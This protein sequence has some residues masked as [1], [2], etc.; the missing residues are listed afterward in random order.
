MEANADLS[1]VVGGKSEMGQPGLGKYLPFLENM[2]PRATTPDAPAKLVPLFGHAALKTQLLAANERGALPASL[3]LQGPRG[4]GKQRLALWLGQ[5]ILCENR[6]RAPCGACT[7]CRFSQ[8][9]VH[10][11]L[12]WYFP[13]PK[14]KEAN[15]SPQEINA[16]L[17]E[18]IAERVAASGVYA[19]P[20]GDEAIFVD[21][22]RAIVQSAVL[23]P[24]M[25]R[26]KAYIIG[27]AERM[28]AQTGADQAANAFLKLLEEPPAD[29]IIILTSSEP[30]ALLP[31][32]KSRVVSIRVGPLLPAEMKAIL[33]DPV[34]A[35]AVSKEHGSAR[36]ADLLAIA[37]GAPGRLL[38]HGAMSAA[39]GAAQAIMEAASSG[40]AAKAFRVAFVQGSSRAR[41]RFSDTLDLLVGLLNERA[42]ANAGRNDRVARGAAAAV[43]AVERAKEFAENNG[44][45]QLIT[46]TLL[47]EITP[48]LS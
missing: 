16:D 41:G 13:R 26:K 42:R 28:V 29:T 22:V 45:P 30:G 17:A 15:P 8:R 47:R 4:V 34:M 36:E 25:A 12:H 33:A 9:L 35:G 11:D 48:L 43:D 19:A 21:T 24:A 39:A 27:D 31:T 3:L 44:N 1:M 14:L 6:D 20:G 23:S 5:V 40:D 2:P 46:A 7:Q 10:P 37:A 38:G 18:A 32:I